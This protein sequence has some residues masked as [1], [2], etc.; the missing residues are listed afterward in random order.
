MKRIN[1]LGFYGNKKFTKETP[2]GAYKTYDYSQQDYQN[3]SLSL[4]VPVLYVDMGYI[5]EVSFDSGLLKVNNVEKDVSEYTIG[6]L[7]EYLKKTYNISLHLITTDSQII[8]NLPCIFLNPFTNV[9]TSIVDGDISPYVIKY[10]TNKS[11]REVE[12]EVVSLKVL[13]SSGEEPYK[14]DDEYI[15]Y[16]VS[17]NCKIYSK[18]VSKI[19]YLFLDTSPKTIFNGTVV[20]N[21]MEYA[22]ENT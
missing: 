22:V 9:K 19:F 1:K 3:L 13:T 7:C 2:V 8:L 20:S 12:S 11:I 17:K 5:L 21:L 4:R 18:I 6:D 16:D 15:Y 10:K 14:K